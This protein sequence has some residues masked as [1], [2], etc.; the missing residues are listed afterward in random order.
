MSSSSHLDPSRAQSYSSQYLK[1]PSSTSATAR[2]PSPHH[3]SQPST[4]SSSSASSPRPPLSIHPTATVADTALIHGTYPITIGGGTVIHPRARLYSYDGP[5]SIGDD[6]IIGEKS[7][8][9]SGPTAPNSSSSNT[10]FSPTSPTSP[11]P[12]LYGYGS[13][14]GSGRTTRISSYVSVAPGA[15]IMPGAHVRSAAVIDSLAIVHRNALVG[16]HSKVCSGC[17]VPENGMVGDWTVVWGAGP[18]FGQ[19]RR[20]RP[21]ETPKTTA[22]TA[23]NN[24]TGS[25]GGSGGVLSPRVV[26]DARLIVMQKEKEALVKMIGLPAGVPRKR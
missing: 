1:P 5:I 24:R 26:E 2:A 9:G 17:E 10:P 6:C 7:V 8:I 12:A 3:R 21:V 25:G 16:T 13:S 15:I 14:A 22:A 23:V 11:S 4:S 20:K 18:R 19:R